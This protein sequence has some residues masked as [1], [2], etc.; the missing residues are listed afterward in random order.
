MKNIL[1]ALALLISTSAVASTCHDGDTQTLEGPYYTHCERV[2]TG[3]RVSAGELLASSGL[4]YEGVFEAS[5]ESIKVGYTVRNNKTPNP[6]ETSLEA[7]T[8]GYETT[9]AK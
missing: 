7:A 3:I 1:I 9:P 4:T 6:G 5:S 8:G 2:I